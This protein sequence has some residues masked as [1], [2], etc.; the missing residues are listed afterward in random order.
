MFR[1]HWTIQNGLPRLLLGAG[2]AYTWQL[3]FLE[4]ALVVAAGTCVARAVRRSP[5][6][7]WIVPG[8]TVLVRMSFDPVI[9]PYY[10]NTAQLVLVIGVAELAMRGTE[11]R[12]RL[13]RRGGEPGSDAAQNPSFPFSRTTRSLP[14]ETP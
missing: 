4:A 10:W 8:A 6:S 14:I 9:Y 12:R 13:T 11:L 1:F 3:R 7:V 2:G 5:S